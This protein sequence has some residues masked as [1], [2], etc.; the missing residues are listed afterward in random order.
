LYVLGVNVAENPSACLIAGDGRTVATSEQHQDG[1]PS[2]V[3]TDLLGRTFCRV[4]VRAVAACLDSVGVELDDLDLVVLCGEVVHTPR[5]QPRNLSV[6]DCMLQLPWSPRSRIHTIDHH[7]AHACSAFYPSGFDDASILVVDR[8]GC[9]ATQAHEASDL[10]PA[11]RLSVRPPRV[12]ASAYRAHGGA[13]RRVFSVEDRHDVPGLAVNS[14]G[15]MVELFAQAIG[16]VDLV[17]LMDLATRGSDRLRRELERHFELTPGGYQLS[18]AVQPEGLALTP[19]LLA[20]SFNVPAGVAAP[21]CADAAWAVGDLLQRVTTHL[22]MQLVERTGARKLCVAGDAAVHGLARLD[23]HHAPWIDQLYVPPAAGEVG[24]AVGAALFGWCEIFGAPPPCELEN[25]FRG[26]PYRDAEIM[27]AIEQHGVARP[28]RS[29]RPQGEVL[30]EVADLLAGGALV[31]WF[32]GGAEL[33][34]PLD[35]RCVLASPCRVPLAPRL[36][37]GLLRESFRALTAVVLVEDAEDYFELGGRSPFAHRVARVV[38]D[39]TR[40]IP[41]VVRSDGTSRV[42]TVDSWRAPR[43][44]D[45]IQRFQ[46]RAGPPVLASAPLRQTGGPAVESPRDAL[47]LW[48]RAEL[49]AIF[50]QGHLL[51]RPAE[52]RVTGD[53]S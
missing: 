39:R 30:D 7:L 31:A 8:G 37:A 40:E 45:L 25:A 44:H 12:R 50:L 28:V 16:C 52:H 34:E 11:T 27:A 29:R 35:R 21:A 43:L 19:G 9:V 32:D 2:V 26:R 46:R 42:Q 18:P 36:D 47:R 17:G 41:L 33:G 13:P 38:R 48:E 4:P 24:T 53:E 22:A 23:P 20:Q 6:A 10:A 5:A 3:R 51:V 1:D 15:A 14:L 49:D